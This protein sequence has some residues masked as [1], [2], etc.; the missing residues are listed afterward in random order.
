MARI[1]VPSVGARLSPPLD[2][3]A[4]VGHYP[5]NKLISRRPIPKRRSFT[6]HHRSEP[7]LSSIISAFTELSLTWGF[8]PTCYYLV[9]RGSKPSRLACLIHA[10]SVHPEL[11][12]NSK[13]NMNG[14]K[15][16]IILI[17]WLF[18]CTS[19]FTSL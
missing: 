3:I 19:L 5:T 17:N 6:E 12:S 18:A 9:C 8:V 13:K 15:E 14:T 11:R 7:G 10:A 4:L 16:K 1:A 2:V